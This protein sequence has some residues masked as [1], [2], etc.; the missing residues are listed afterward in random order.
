MDLKDQRLIEHGFPCHQVGA[1]TQRERGASS[2][3]PPLYFL[4]V[5]WA[6]RP[7]TPSRAAILASLSPADTDPESFVRQLGIERIEA[8]VNGVPWTL[9][10]DLLDRVVKDKDGSEFLPVDPFVVR[11]LQA[12]QGRRD[13]NLRLIAGI[14]A[15]DPSLANDPVLQ[16][17]E[18]ESDPIPGPW[19]D[20]GG[21][22]RV[23]RVAGDPAWAKH[24]I[25]WETAQGIRTAED[26]YGYRRAY[27]NP[28]KSEPSGMVVLDPTS[29]GGSIPFEALRL[30][31]RVIANELNPVGAVIL[32]A[33]LD[34]PTRFG[35]ELADD[36]ESWGK[37]LWREMVDQLHDLF[38]A[39]PLT[40]EEKARLAH[41]L[42]QCPELIPQYDNEKLDG[43]IYTRQVICP[44]CGGEAP[45]LNTC[46]LSKEAGDLWG[47]K[48]AA[49]GKPRNGKVF[50]Q[51]YRVVK[52]KG[53]GGEDPNFA[54]VVRGVGRCIHCRQAITGEEIKAQARGESPPGRWQDRLYAVVAV[55]L[56][57]KLDKH[58]KPQRFKSGPR[59]GEIM[60]WKV[61]FFRP[62]NELDL[63]A[64]QTAEERLKAKWDKWEAAGII[65]TEGIPDGNDMRPVLYGMPRWC[66]LFTPRQLLGHLTL[67]EGLNRLKPGIIAELGLDRGRALVTYLQFAIDKGLDYNSKQTRWEYTRGIVKGTFS[68][69]DFSLK[70][71]FGEMIFTGPNSGA[72]WRLSQVVDAYRGIAELLEPLHSL[73]DG[74]SPLPV[75]ILNQTA[76]HMPQIEDR[77][78]DLVCMD[79]PYYNNVQYAELSDYFY[80]WQKRTLK[81]LYPDLFHLR[82]TN[83]REEAVANPVRDGSATAA[84]RAYEKMMG[85]I[86]SEC[87]RVLKDDGLLTLMFT[88]KEQGAWETLTRSLIEAGWTITASFPVE[89]EA[90][91]SL[92]QRDMAAAASSIFITCRKRERTHKEPAMWTG[93]GGRGVQRQVTDAVQNALEEFV[94]L[95]LN[96]V[97]EMVACYGRTLHVLSRNWPVMDGDEPVGPMRAML[98]ASRVVAAN[99]VSRITAGRVKVGE[100]DTETGMA[101]TLFGIY[102]L[103][104]FPY[105]EALSLSRSLNIALAAKPAG[106]RVE[107]RMIGINR[108][109]GGGTARS[110]GAGEQ[111]MGYHAPLVRAGSK[112]RLAK[113]EE[114]DERRM[115][116]PQTDWDVLHGLIQ[117]YRRGDAP[118]A[119]GYLNRHAGENPAK[120]LDLLDVWAAEVSVEGLRKEA[121]AMRFDLNP[122]AGN[123]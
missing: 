98:E 36:I 71:T 4:H 46:W 70:W 77:S 72:A 95:N 75:A 13:E 87:R 23:R 30:G 31:H 115:E 34:F 10:G 76:A 51:T 89:S 43:F 73:F 94:A 103:S 27:A 7:L 62:P 116:Q 16:R 68:R 54:T 67:V 92:H 114:R 104:S 47:V 109:S 86:F 29:G 3:L 79:P 12:E 18:E 64:L 65:P 11:A 119:R 39:S 38:P 17:W 80:V 26:K 105:D 24:R 100:L 22:L 42:S 25:A 1:E 14:R 28:V 74:A 53:P 40:G 6:R 63:N 44:G 66:D 85:E 5:W 90:A 52:G 9:T 99:Q 45:L 57:P 102:G 82:L 81:D 101:L 69:H 110:R 35:R 96:P 59:A 2:A 93:L 15:K 32:Y 84:K 19:P 33:T 108:E 113:P 50:F 107:G 120:V 55:R 49:D 121:E 41:H 118:V 60:T 61:R 20:V 21:F 78:V 106:Y 37:Q 112:L 8:I 58:G 122:R 123:R 88:H 111:D 83:K 48:V 56:E 117:A 91:A 97:D